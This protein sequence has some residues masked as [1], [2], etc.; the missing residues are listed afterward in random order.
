MTASST[1]VEN[2][3]GCSVSSNSDAKSSREDYIASSF[4]KLDAPLRISETDENESAGSSES[5]LGVVHESLRSLVGYGSCEKKG[6]EDVE[7]A[8]IGEDPLSVGR[9][10]S[11]RPTR[12]A[13]SEE[14]KTAEEERNRKSPKAKLINKVADFRRSIS[15]SNDF[16]TVGIESSESSDPEE[17]RSNDWEIRM[18]AEELSKMEE[19][20]DQ[21][22]KLQQLEE[23][24]KLEEDVKALKRVVCEGTLS[25]F[26][27]SE[28]DML[29]TILEAKD[30]RI[31]EM[32]SSSCFDIAG[33]ELTKP[34]SRLRGRY[35]CRRKIG[36][37][38]SFDF[39]DMDDG[40]QRTHRKR[41]SGTD[42]DGDR[43]SLDDVSRAFGFP[44]TFDESAASAC[45]SDDINQR[46]HPKEIRDDV[47][48]GTTS[49]LPPDCAACR[50]PGKVSDGEDFADSVRRKAPCAEANAFRD[51]VP[52]ISRP[53]DRDDLQRPDP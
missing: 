10:R 26:S 23:M 32:A 12:N 34:N 19:D 7:M 6:F 40:M 5:M 22:S 29:E 24:K 3:M 2:R 45:F 48:S 11:N 37:A 4:R 17:V 13:V 21:E 38:A 36:Q 35:R 31:S 47:R 33:H 25:R 52:N 9:T 20:E 1:G 28:L 8:E 43:V 15:K 14:Q 50:S 30:Q 44:R 53:P 41:D 46:S 16:V 42:P 39:H 51:Q 49:V 18:L 27:A